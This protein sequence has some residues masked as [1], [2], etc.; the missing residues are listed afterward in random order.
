MSELKADRRRLPRKRTLKGARIIFNA[1]NSMF[2]CVVRNLSPQGALLLMP[3]V[4]GIPSDFDL[5]IKGEMSGHPAHVVWR[6]TG[7][8][9]VSWA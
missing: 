7:S 9:G 4:V 1:R 8:L 6:S 3:Y 5:S 2:D